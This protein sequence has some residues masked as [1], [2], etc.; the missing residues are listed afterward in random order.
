[1]PNGV[2]Y[3]WARIAPGW[4]GAMGVVALTCLSSFQ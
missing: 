2:R 3:S 4:I 1:M